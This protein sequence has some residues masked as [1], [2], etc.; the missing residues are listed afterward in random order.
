MLPMH[1]HELLRD[2]AQ[3][4]S[5]SAFAELVNRHVG[6]VYSAALR[7]VRDPH[8]AEDVTQAVFIVLARKA[9]RLPGNTVL[10]GWL[11]KTTRF[12]ANAQIRAAIRRAQREQEVAMQSTLNES[13]SAIW[14][15]LAPRLDEAM[16]ALG[17]ADRNTIA[18]RYFKNKTAAEIATALKVTEE[19]A[20]KRVTRALEKLRMI[21]SKRAVTLSAVA[22][23]GAVSANSV[24]AAPVGLVA[25]VT[26]A[27]A[28]GAGISAGMTTLVK[29]AL[30]LM[31]WT[32]AKTAIVATA[33]VLL[34]AGT[35]TVVVE[36]VVHP[37]LSATDL[38][39]ADN[40]KYWESN[41]QV[42]G[43]NPPVF[44]LRPTRFPNS[45]G[46]VTM[47]R[48][49]MYKN[50]RLEG[51][52]ETA[53]GYSS[54]RTIFPPDMP[55]EAYDLMFTLPQDPYDRLKQ[56]IAGRFGYTAH[57]EER[58][59]DVLLLKVKTP[60][61]SGL[62]PTR[63]NEGNT[64]WSSSDTETI[65]QNHSID[66]ARSICESRCN[67]PV[68]DRTGMHGKYDITLRGRMNS[69]QECERLVADQLGLE[70][71]PSREPIKMLVVERVK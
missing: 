7:Q 30:K 29:G 15:Q 38:A 36:H 21:F 11:I 68:L 53:Y 8:Q 1:D 43:K 54:Q 6:L 19:A 56:E 66:A 2:Y 4:Q 57:E 26:A 17:E 46:G 48:R 45:G 41:S 64:F 49:L 10:S 28:K 39:W 13:D 35:T 63:L 3:S 52:I 47:N 60:D 44:I 32:K 27:A 18:L 20:Q 69:R 55:K 14:E 37:K 58:V 70:L 24:Q 71:V 25:T 23:A 34:A 67:L 51:L 40:P 59:T 5:E 12:A 31:S 65:I 9:G 50:T 16:A 33:G 42:L 62:K 22:I 61:A